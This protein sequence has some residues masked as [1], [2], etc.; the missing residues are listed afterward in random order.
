ML[1]HYY[2]NGQVYAHKTINL[3][4]LAFV[5]CC[6]CYCSLSDPVFFHLCLSEAGFGYFGIVERI[7]D[8]VMISFIFFYLF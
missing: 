3:L 8:D 2:A 1:S 6:S 5:S 7:E 4:L